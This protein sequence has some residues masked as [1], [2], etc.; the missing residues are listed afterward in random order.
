MS[1][2]SQRSITI[3]TSET[4]STF[5]HQALA[6]GE[7]WRE[8]GLADEITPLFTG[9]SVDNAHLVASGEADFGCM[10]AN[11]LPLAAT[12]KTP[13]S[14]ALPVRL[15]T[16]INTGPLFFVAA[17]SSSLRS[18]A[19]LKGKR[20]ALG[21]A[22]SGMV[23]HIHTQFG[24]LGLPLETIEPVYVNASEGGR[25]LIDGKVDA[26]F[27]MPI[28]NIHFTELSKRL[29]LRVLPYTAE[30]RKRILGAVPYYGEATIPKGAFPGH[31]QD[32]ATVGVINVLAVHANAQ[33]E[34]VY[35]LTRAMITH[36]NDLA[37]R[38]PLFHGLDKLLASAP[39]GII[40]VMEK[41]GVRQHAG[42]KRAFG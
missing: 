10:A 27:Q 31:D 6:L 36:A 39:S 18:F 22:N 15:M 5:H 17:A 30:E 38:N 40:S 9:G 23:Q 25:M 7:L 14:K 33:D 13:F 2:T 16:P 37:R 3:G 29:P 42:A 4:D 1:L 8:E 28:P 35:R 20:V 26:V 12:G 34:W 21:I 32:V 41:A 19:D 24:A 11:W